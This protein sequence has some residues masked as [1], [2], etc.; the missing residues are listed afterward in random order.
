MA[1]TAQITLN[2][3]N[4]DAKLNLQ[5]E[6]QNG[7]K[8]YMPVIADT[9]TLTTERT[10]TPGKLEFSVIWDQKLKIE[11]GNPVKLTV[12]KK[13]LFYG[14]IFTFSHTKSSVVKITAYDQVRYLLN[15]DTYYF[16]KQTADSIIKM[17]AKD[18]GLRV[19]SI[20]ETGYTIPARLMDNKTLLD[21]M[22]DS[23]EITLTNNK[24]L[25]CLYDKAGKL[26]LK[27]SA[28]MKIGLLIDADTAEDFDYSSTIDSGV[29]NVIK[30]VYEKDGKR[31]AYVAQDKATQKKWGS[32]Q[33][34][35]KIDDTANANNKAKTL[36]NLYN[37]K[38]KA[39]TVRNCLGD[40]R[41]RAGCMVLVRLT[42]H[43]MKIS[44]WMLVETCT[45]KFTNNQHTMTLKLRGGEFAG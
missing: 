1:E 4:G 15:K 34:F 16:K 28:D 3:I 11:E 32:L 21:M 17:V 39:L 8:G 26:T 7:K 40:V 14:F 36:L 27:Q 5:I 9:V 37:L 43:D 25:F 29:Y 18:Y 6:I 10:D 35:E 20:A 22:Q 12:N 38:N 24:K 13:V 33:Y 19:G 44:N 23:L 2:K 42:L 31:T 45:H 30:L 41:V